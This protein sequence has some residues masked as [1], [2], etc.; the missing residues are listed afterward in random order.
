MQPNKQTHKEISWYLTA[1]TYCTV[2]SEQHFLGLLCTVSFFLPNSLV[3]FCCFSAVPTRY[4]ST[5]TKGAAPLP[6]PWSSSHLSTPASDQEPLPPPCPRDC[7]RAL[8]SRTRP[9]AA[10][11]PAARGEEGRAVLLRGAWRHPAAVSRYCSTER[12]GRLRG[13]GGLAERL[14]GG[15]VPAM[16]S[17]LAP[18]L[19]RARHGSTLG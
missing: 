6:A 4:A 18:P 9:A 16:P 14:G 1:S 11:P 19:P 2:I 17:P 7:H 13:N 5:R 10:R 15:G 12:E 3:S 8:S